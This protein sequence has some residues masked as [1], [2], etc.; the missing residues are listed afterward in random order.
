MSSR[1][2][3]TNSGNDCCGSS[4]LSFVVVVDGVTYLCSSVVSVCVRAR[5][6]HWSM[7]WPRKSENARLILFRV[8]VHERVIKSIR[9]EDTD[10]KHCFAAMT[11]VDI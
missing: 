1:L 3:D 2:A 11:C 7:A 9:F 5:E 4:L 10:S 8:I 6:L